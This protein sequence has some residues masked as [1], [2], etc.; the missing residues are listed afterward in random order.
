MNILKFKK[1]KINNK[2]MTL[3]ET[4]TSVAIFAIVALFIHNGISLTLNALDVG[5]FVYDSNS[6]LEQKIETNMTTS[7]N[8]TASFSINSTTITLAGQ[9]H[10]AK[11][12]EG[13]M[14][15]SYTFFKP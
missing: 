4:I 14:N 7:V 12:T 1:K 9:Y 2:G 5:D 6:K 13:D 10:T 15:I 11:E 8:D 3:I